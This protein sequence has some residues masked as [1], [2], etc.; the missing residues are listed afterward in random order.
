MTK[1]LM[2]IVLLPLVTTAGTVDVW[3]VDASSWKESV[4][5]VVWIKGSVEDVAAVD[6]LFTA[7]NSTT[8]ATLP[9]AHITRIGDDVGSGSL[10]RR[11][12]IWHAYADVGALK[13]DNVALTVELKS[14]GGVQPTGVQ[15][16]ENGPYWAEWNVG[17]AS[18]EDYGY[19]FS[20]GDVVG[21]KCKEEISTDVFR[22]YFNVTWVSS[23]G[24]CMDVNKSP[25]TYSNCPIYGKS[26]SQLRSEGCIDSMGNLTAAYDAATAHWGAP[27][28][29]PTKKEFA[30][31]CE[32]CRTTW[33]IRNGVYGRL[34]TGKGSYSAKSIFLPDAGHGV[35]S[36]F[37]PGQSGSYWSSTSATSADVSFD[38][39]S[40]FFNVSDF[41]LNNMPDSYTGLSVRPVRE[42]VAPKTMTAYFT[43]D[44]RL[45][46]E[47][48]YVET[49]DGITWNYMVNNG[50][51]QVG[52]GLPG[53]CAVSK[54]LGGAITIPSALGGCPVTSIGDYAFDDCHLTSVTIPSSVTSIGAAAFSGSSIKSVTIPEGV[55]NIGSSAFSDCRWLTSVTIPEGVE[56]IG[57]GAF[58]GCLGLTSVTIPSSVMRIGDYAFSNCSGL[59][60]VF[61]PSG[62]VE[63][64]KNMYKWQ[65]GV[66]FVEI[67]RP[68][69][70]GDPGATV[71]GD[72]ETG[73]VIKPSEG[74]TVVEVTIP[75][76]VDAAKVM[77]EV[78]VK[79][80]SVKPNGAKVKIVSGGAD[81]TEFLDLPAADGD[82]V[83]DLTKATVKDEI[84]KEALD[85]AKGAVIDLCSGSQGTASPTIMTAPM[86]AG[87]FYQF[88]E[89]ETLG[90]MKDGDSKVGDGQPWSPKITVKGGNS[91]F[92][93]IGVG[94]GG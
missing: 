30:A 59:K 13:V 43:L 90:G 74:K 7:A 14:S 39:W 78:S 42:F 86:R 72:A 27:W 89:G 69:I 28:R 24:V 46:A 9:I 44:C 36:S 52:T 34:V 94:K 3:G 53:D 8:D 58:S 60:T 6:C 62:D 57:R 84:V 67:L 18:A 21:Y 92:Y 35:G 73:F 63:R 12:F 33:T 85:P 87:L 48:S 10:W 41:Y 17:A 75:Q 29:M 79:V 19:Y 66:A 5:V 70:D 81:I 77:V 65:S 11:E 37:Y 54:G 31:L 82:G 16:W 45:P 56:N 61:A 49:V 71:T 2:A 64:V 40:L 76:D 55:R 50:E 80:V 4:N 93:S 20:W 32:N 23:Q 38:P 25:F 83:V 15:L 1:F 26:N 22:T 51:A 88:R 91:A 47:G 68:V